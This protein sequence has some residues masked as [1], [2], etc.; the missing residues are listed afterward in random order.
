[1]RKALV[2]PCSLV[3][4]LVACGGGGST[5]PTTPTGAT[6]AS[7]STAASAAPS[8]STAPLASASATPTE[9]N[10]PDPTESAQ[11]LT[12]T[13]LLTKT[14]PKASFPKKTIGD[15]ECWQG[16][17]VSGDAQKDFTAILAKCGAPTGLAEYAKPVTGRL[18]HKVDKRD[19]YTLKLAGGLCYRYFAV[20]DGS[21]KDLDI[22]VEKPGGALVADDKTTSPVA[23][24]E[25]SKPWCMDDD[26]EYN[27]QIEVDGE[28]K[29]GYVFGVW[30]RP[31]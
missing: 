23:I 6:S 31:K 13:P 17:G 14:T 1:M 18:H 11:V 9:T 16:L 12:M 15:Q 3:L 29:G 5:Q 4:V 2:L 28:G 22:L 30:A 10:D 27:F 8:G 7:T 24:I 26:A 21:I 19:S 25:G 20:A